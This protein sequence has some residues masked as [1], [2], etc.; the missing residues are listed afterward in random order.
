MR[1]WN[2]LLPPFSEERDK[3]LQLCRTL[4]SKT[5]L[6]LLR[7]RFFEILRPFLILSNDECSNKR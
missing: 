5:A 2:F 3:S 1:R 4:L 6:S 7:A